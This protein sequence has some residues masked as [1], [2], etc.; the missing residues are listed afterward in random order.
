MTLTFSKSYK[1]KK[2]RFDIKNSQSKRFIQEYLYE[3]V[4]KY[5]ICDSIILSGPNYWAHIDNAY[6]ILHNGYQIKLIEIDKYVFKNIQKLHKTHKKIDIEQ[7]SQI[8][9]INQDVRFCESHRFEDLD[10]MCTLTGNKNSFAAKRLIKERIDK[11]IQS[12]QNH[13][14]SIIFT[15]CRRKISYNDTK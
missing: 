7:A 9:V 2:D 4:F 1:I 15:V 3:I 6:P 11:Q 12:F 14:K 10:L 13:I 5:V 8:T